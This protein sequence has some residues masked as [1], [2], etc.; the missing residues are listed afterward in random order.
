MVIHGQLL[1]GDD[2]FVETHRH[3]RSLLV[4]ILF[5]M[6]GQVFVIVAHAVPEA[7]AAARECYAGHNEEINSVS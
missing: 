5:S 6:L 7:I 4:R 2:L 1:N 3:Y